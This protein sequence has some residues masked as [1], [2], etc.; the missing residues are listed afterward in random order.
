MSQLTIYHQLIG[1]P[2]L[3]LGKQGVV[4]GIKIMN[5][6]PLAM[7]HDKFEKALPSPFH[8]DKWVYTAMYGVNELKMINQ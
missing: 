5:G 7:V 6:E 8:A 1:Q 4:V 2:C 3:C